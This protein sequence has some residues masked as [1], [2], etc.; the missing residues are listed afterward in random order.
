MMK[1][2]KD[3]SGYWLVHGT[4]DA[5]VWE[6]TNCNIFLLQIRTRLTINRIIFNPVLVDRHL[7]TS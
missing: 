4:I 2:L 5:R 3:M 6:L 1:L 7:V